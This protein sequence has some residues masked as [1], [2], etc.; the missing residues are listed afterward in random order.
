MATAKFTIQR[1]KVGLK[2]V[3][4]AAGSAEAQSDTLSVNVDYTKLTKGE[5]V[6][7][8]QEVIQK[9]QGGKWPP[10]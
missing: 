5:T 7:L 3:V 1:G 10:L 9:I 2:D 6:I 8:L 4:V